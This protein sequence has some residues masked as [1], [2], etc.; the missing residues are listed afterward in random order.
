MNQFTYQAINYSRVPSQDATLFIM[1]TLAETAQT[2][3]CEFINLSE[4]LHQ[5]MFFGQN[6]LKLNFKSGL[7][8]FNG[9]AL[10]LFMHGSIVLVGEEAVSLNH[11]SKMI[12]PSRSDIKAFKYALSLASYEFDES[13]NIEHRS[14][15]A[16]I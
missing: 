14:H 5:Y 6:D 7:K 4:L 10:W 12:K 16:H 2:T 8:K 11:S 1:R 13:V 9:A 3:E 15:F